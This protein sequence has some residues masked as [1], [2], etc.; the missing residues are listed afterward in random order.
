MKQ[1]KLISVEVKNYCNHID[2]IGL[3]F[4]DSKTTVLVGPN[5]SGK[6]S[7]LQAIPYAFY[8]SCEKG[9]GEDVL[10]N[11]TKKN[12]LIYV[13]F[14]VDDDEYEVK[15]YVKYTKKGTTVTLSKNGKLTHTGS[16]EVVPEIER[17]ILPKKLFNN[18][19]LF[20][21]KVKTFFTDLTDS[22]QKDI[23]RKILKLDDYVLYGKETTKRINEINE[24][25]RK[26]ET[27][28]KVNEELKTSTNNQIKLNKELKIKFESEKQKNLL[29]FKEK[30]NSL[31]DSLK[32]LE[33]SL[34]FFDDD[35][36]NSLIELIKSNT[37]SQQELTKTDEKLK[38]V[39][40]MINAGA[41]LK[42]LE[43]TR[44]AKSA[45]D[46]LVK[47]HHENQQQIKES[48]NNDIKG[49]E[50]LR[51][52]SKE[53]RDDLSNK[54]VAELSPVKYLS[55]DVLKL[56]E[57]RSLSECPTCKRPMNK[58]G[59]E[60]INFNIEE[61]QDKI[62]EIKSNVEK[63]KKHIDEKKESV[64]S[65][66]KEIERLKNLKEDRL[67][68]ASDD[69]DESNVII[70]ERFTSTI[71]KLEEMVKAEK[72]NRKSKILEEEKE[73]KN[74]VKDLENKK[75]EVEESIKEKKGVE[76]KINKMIS[77][78]DKEELLYK[79]KSEETFDE[80]Q[81]IELEKNLE[82]LKQECTQL[83]KS[84]IELEEII[85]VLEFWKEGF[86]SSGIQSM[87][88]DESIP[89]L[90]LRVKYYMDKICNGRYSVSFDTLST[91]K[92][93]EFRDKISVELFDTE[94]H[95]DDRVKF[96]GGQERMVDIGIILSLGDLQ[97]M[98]HGVE[99]NILMFDE[100]FDALDES[101]I[102]YVSALLSQLSKDKCIVIISHRYIDQL[103]YDEE[104]R[105]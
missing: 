33:L 52:K 5:G 16:K 13:K 39:D 43:I 34:D 79:N 55:N 84:M 102:G 85:N 35:L 15:R 17:L 98:I 30:I 58:E 83:K 78:I 14:Q 62:N 73:L 69:F 80:S 19:L 47:N 96:S 63:R 2:P 59:E 74:K 8:G 9:R 103:E 66:D 104:L 87:L 91:T 99:F 51:D 31:N 97:S 4:E 45:I 53:I 41:E 50:R 54:S 18:T 75:K 11:K 48:F 12:C 22:E 100:I 89:Y 92:S 36:D 29:D 67:K 82:F 68:E 71:T 56:E 90:N 44:D 46:D 81:L 3:G 42:K 105:F 70:N 57:I 61:I 72:S 38:E 23:F 7:L 21:Q 94:T 27:D 40:D 25:I 88:I 1:V 76:E 64:I 101:N 60:T 24:D 65:L 28:I 26:L 77:S 32:E 37:I 20:G 86:S 93:G 10:N 49:I 6:T 95:S